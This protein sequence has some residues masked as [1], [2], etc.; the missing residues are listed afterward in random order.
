MILLRDDTRPVAATVFPFSA[1]LYKFRPPALQE[2]AS[3]EGDPG[4][5]ISPPE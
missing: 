1:T 2:H 5:L 4:S 3:R